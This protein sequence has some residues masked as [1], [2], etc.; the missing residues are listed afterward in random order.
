MAIALKDEKII[1]DVTS[2]T[3]TLLNTCNAAK[4]NQEEQL[5]DCLNTIWNYDKITP[6]LSVIR[7]LYRL[8]QNPELLISIFLAKGLGDLRRILT[9]KFAVK[10]EPFVEFLKD[11]FSISNQ[12]IRSAKKTYISDLQDRI[13]SFAY[14]NNGD[15]LVPIE[16]RR[17]EYTNGDGIPLPLAIANEDENFIVSEGFLEK[18]I[19]YFDFLLNDN[20]V[21][22]LYHKKILDIEKVSGEI[23]YLC[24]LNKDVG[25]NGPVVLIDK[26]K[27]LFPFKKFMV[28]NQD[29]RTEEKD[30]YIFID[31]DPPSENDRI[32]INYD[33][34]LSGNG[35]QDACQKI[36][37]KFDCDV[38]G[39]VV[40][41]SST[42]N[43]VSKKYNIEAIFG[44]NDLPN[45][46]RLYTID[47]KTIIKDN[48]L[49][50][51]EGKMDE[52]NITKII[53]TNDSVGLIKLLEQDEYGTL[54][55]LFRLI[56]KKQ[57]DPAL[58]KKSIELWST[59]FEYYLENNR[60]NAIDSLCERLALAKSEY[61]IITTENI[62]V[63]FATFISA[64]L[65]AGNPVTGAKVV[66]KIHDYALS[67]GKGKYR[68]L[69]YSNI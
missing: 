42:E 1:G 44:D 20:Q 31:C 22:E 16:N 28:Y 66:K 69:L 57:F 11:I 8:T 30:R 13:Y 21:L 15:Y 37:L 52:H 35:I 38:I 14:K 25:P 7:N 54:D 24:F 61:K 39:V 51:L 45:N 29:H 40:L 56:D 32:S 59:I 53:S 10:N 60:E 33:L 4:D 68:N 18:Y 3:Y 43:I 48:T 67:Y 41:Y 50:N 62:F 49:E 2:K 46:A 34:V 65:V 5:K 6:R 64:F 17:T 19:L 9:E 55:R 47:R 23:D 12:Y 27:E 58:R 36:E 63:R 26:F